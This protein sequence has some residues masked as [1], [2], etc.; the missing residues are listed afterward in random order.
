MEAFRGLLWEV[1]ALG[2]AIIVLPPEKSAQALPTR[3]LAG[4]NTEYRKV[5]VII[6]VTSSIPNEALFRLQRTPHNVNPIRP[7]RPPKHPPLP[8]ASP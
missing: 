6:T 4:A 7:K 2:T 8:G 1:L 5:K 3:M